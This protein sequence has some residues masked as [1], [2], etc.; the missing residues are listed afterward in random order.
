MTTT[1]PAPTLD[2][3]HGTSLVEAYLHANPE[4]RG[5]IHATLQG[6]RDS[7][8]DLV[9]KHLK[10]MIDTIYRQ[11]RALVDP[12]T[13][14]AA[15]ARM[16]IAELAV[17]ARH[18]AQF[19]RLAAAHVYGSCPAL[20]H[21]FDRNFLEEGGEPGKVPAH[22]ILYTRALLA[23][24]GLLVNG[25]V[26]A[27]ETAKLVLQHQV[28]VNSHMTGLIAG[29][30]YATEGVAVAETEILRDI[31]NRYGE[32]TIQASSAELQNLDY[33]YRL[34]LDEDHEGAQI[35]GMSVEESHIEGLA[36][37]IRQSDL[38]HLDLPQALEG[39]LQI[40]NAMAHWWTQLAYR[41]RDLN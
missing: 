37:F 15:Q 38:F 27:D 21:E 25:H 4:T 17:F 22:Y 14:T 3:L 8:D 41:A 23:D 28:L 20:G 11:I 29:G 26:P 33:Y 36:R 40:F 16:Y 32:L 12:G 6:N 39:F 19:L 10:P 30:Y 9:D 24:L 34:H 5:Y 18:N 35:G 1:A 2:T 13:L 7:G 31:T